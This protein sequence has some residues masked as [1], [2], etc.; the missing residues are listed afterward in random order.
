MPMGFSQG[1]AS[2]TR[3]IKIIYIYQ[4]ITPKYKILAMPL[5]GME[6]LIH[7]NILVSL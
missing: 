2:D 6:M 5:V 3:I 7:L 1:K 4:K